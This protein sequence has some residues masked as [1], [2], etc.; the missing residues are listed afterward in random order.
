MRFFFDLRAL[1]NPSGN[2]TAPRYFEGFIACDCERTW[3]ETPVCPRSLAARAA[4]AA[5]SGSAMGLELEKGEAAGALPHPENPRVSRQRVETRRQKY[6]CGAGPA[7]VLPDTT[8]GPVSRHL[9]PVG[10]AGWPWTVL[11]ESQR[12]PH[13]RATRGRSRRPVRDA[14]PLPPCPPRPGQYKPDPY[15]IL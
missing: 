8:T 5:G 2:Q 6:G 3:S 15:E 1:R 4:G 14:G 10:A 11:S 7:A 13:A 12:G 9:W